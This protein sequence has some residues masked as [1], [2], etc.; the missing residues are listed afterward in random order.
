MLDIITIGDYNITIGNNKEE[1]YMLNELK[2]CVE[3]LRLTKTNEEIAGALAEYARIV[4][5][6]A[7][8]YSDDTTVEQLLKDHPE[9]DFMDDDE[10]EDILKFAREIRFK[11]ETTWTVK[12]Q[13]YDEEGNLRLETRVNKEEN[14]KP[15]MKK[16]IK[17]KV[18]MKEIDQLME[19]AENVN[20]LRDNEFLADVE[21]NIDLNKKE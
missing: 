12:E 6:V 21:Y 15:K 18:F 10:I 19:V 1:K 14:L 4:K 7:E 3:E 20:K 9:L 17:V 16:P 5:N 13:I 8:D 11:R 2:E